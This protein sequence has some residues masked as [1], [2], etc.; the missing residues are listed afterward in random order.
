MI[1]VNNLVKSYGYGKPAVKGVTFSIEKGE[2]VGLLGPNGAGKSTIMKIIT[3]YL[4]PTE[5]E[6]LVDGLNTIDNPIEIKSKIGYLPEKTPLYQDMIVYEYL[7]FISEIRGIPKDKA[8]EAI[9]KMIELVALEEVVSKKISQLSNG[10]KKRVGLASAMMHDPEILI[11]D[12]P[13]AGLDPNQIIMFRKI[14]RKLSEKKTIILSTHVLSEIEAMCEKVIVIN[15]GTKVADD[16][17]QE[18]MKKFDKELFID[19]VV[20]GE[21]LASVE[22]Q[23]SELKGAWKIEFEKKESKN[24]FRFKALITEGS[25]F[26]NNLKNHSGNWKLVSSEKK[27][28]NLEEIFLKLTALGGENA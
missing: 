16:N 24:Q 5:G 4:N 15:N 2:I 10:Y 27:K 23:V 11:L 1:S 9:F 14:L 8:D 17:I 18:L 20:E 6:V 13:T 28:A 12:E 3:G 21:N 19:F 26:E 22:S 7:K 25:D